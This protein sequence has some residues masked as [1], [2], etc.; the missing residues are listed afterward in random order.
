MPGIITG[1]I[2]AMARGAGEVA[3]LVLV[4]AKK[5]APALPIDSVFPRVI[6]RP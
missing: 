1:M 6:F 4:G 5:N 3:P 2:L